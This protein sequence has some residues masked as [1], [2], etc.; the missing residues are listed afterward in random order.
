MAYDV[1]F[2]SQ[3]DVKSLNIEMGEMLR[4]IE[5]GWKLKGEGKAELPPKPG[6]HPRENCYIH[7]MP[8]WI[9][10]EVD[11]AGLKWVAGY[12]QNL[13]KKLPYN[14]GI[15]CLNDTE[16]GVITAIM[17]ANW[18][19]TWRT[20]AASGVGA[21]YLASPDTATMSVIG[22]G[23][24]G[25]INLRAIK[26]ALPSIRNVKLFDPLPSQTN[27]FISEMGGV[28]PD[29]NFT[30]AAEIEEACADSDI[31][32][33]S[34]PIVENPSRPGK[35]AW[36]KKDALVIATDYDSTFDAD[37][38]SKA[39]AFVCDDKGQYLWAQEH[40]VYFQ[41]GYPTSAG[42]YADMGE[43]CAGVKKPVRTGRRTCVFMGIASHDVM[44][45]RLILRKAKEAEIGQWLKL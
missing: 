15:F 10:G 35:A 11:T 40:G 1:L 33:S 8:C 6:V 20:G 22:L 24:I 26:T 21:K 4:E 18:M 43:I 38:A 5:L 23:T 17:D 30:T 14:N 19:T 28:F 9:G 41:N 3:D 7:A 45:A 36:L 32:T 42:I 31:V 2:L 44:T 39:E 27:A 13:G 16:T 37:T 25:K 34:A 29:L 12:P